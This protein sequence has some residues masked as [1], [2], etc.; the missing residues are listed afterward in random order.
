MAT[1]EHTQ[2]MQKLAQQK[3]S[4]DFAV[5]LNRFQQIQRTSAE[6]SREYVARARAQTAHLERC[7]T[8]MHSGSCPS[9]DDSMDQQPLM[10]QEHQRQQELVKLDHEIEYNESIIAEREQS[11]VEIE[12][13]I[14]EVN[15][16]FRDLGSLVN[17]QQ[18]MIGACDM[19]LCVY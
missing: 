9:S 16:I 11:I 6:K 10:Y 17:D 14:V 13:A 18:G 7:D 4:K 3:L 19:C 12:H 5:V 8:R 2:R 15:E 1:T